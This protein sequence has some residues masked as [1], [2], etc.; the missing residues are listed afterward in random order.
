M[1]VI[2][3]LRSDDA[4]FYPYQT[5][6]RKTPFVYG[7]STAPT[8]DADA[9][10]IGGYR[11]NFDQAAA[12]KKCLHYDW[13]YSGENRARTVLV[14]VLFNTLPSAAGGLVSFQLGHNYMTLSHYL[15]EVIY[16]YISSA[17]RI[18]TY[19]TDEANASIC[20]TA[21]NS[22]T[23]VQDQWH[24]LVVQWDGSGGA[25]SI[26]YYLDGAAVSTVSPTSSRDWPATFPDYAHKVLTI[27]SCVNG[28][29]TRCYIN[30][31]VVW[32]NTFDVTAAVTLTTGT[33]VLSGST[34]SYF[35]AATAQD[36]GNTTDPGESNVRNGT[37]Y[38]VLG[39]QK[40]G[41]VV[42]PADNTV[43]TGTTFEHNSEHTGTYDGSD[44]WT[45]P[46]E[47]NVRDGTAYKA[48]STS[49][50]KEG[51]LDL[52]AEA[53]VKDGV[54]YDG[55]SKE[56]TYVGGGGDFPDEADVRDG[57]EYN[58]GALTGTLDLPTEANVRDGVTYDGA[59]KEGTLDLPSINDVRL[60]TQFDQTSKTGL[61]D[62]PSVDDVRIGVDFDQESK[63]G[64]MD[65]P[66]EADVKVG[67]NF[68]NGTKLGTYAP[69]VWNSEMFGDLT[70]GQALSVLYAICAGKSSVTVE[71]GIATVVFKGP[72]D[73]TTRATVTVDGSE[74]TAFVFNPPAPEGG[75]TENL[76]DT[77]IDN[78]MT[79]FEMFNVILSVVA[80]KS[81][82]TPGDPGEATVVFRD[83]ADEVDLITASMVDNERV[84]VVINWG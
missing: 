56:G 76:W 27:G 63:T 61:L 45:D 38:Y 78:A 20:S 10:S 29:N 83:G 72:D 8:R 14:R 48:N 59:T 65:L 66:D 21:S 53:D 74:R 19:I 55:G 1:G 75:F 12:D 54:L 36:G 23:Y 35:V 80:G 28:I 50:N 11:Y 68:D 43:K 30:E 32:D 49:N 84:T 2:F 7:A 26:K 44:R 13:C 60:G 15:F 25:N 47:A 3:S 77:E 64:L 18:A 40:T 24:D 34:R 67:V 69:I 39:I 70:A 46:G 9:N 37:S 17:R 41:N 22:V 33:G 51:T 82:V 73:T 31:V 81:T 58:S 5:A 71:E 57:V 16:S 62:L 79:A 6:G 4:S 42:I 52:P